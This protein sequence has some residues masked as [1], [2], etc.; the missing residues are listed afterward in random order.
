M[1][2]LPFGEWL[3]DGP[4]FANPGTI[5]ALNVVPRTASSYGPMPGPV[6]YT[7][8]LPAQVCGSYGYRDA[9]GVVFNFAA[10]KSRIYLQQTG[11]TAFTDI[12]GPSAPYNTENPPDG[13]WSMT[14]FGKRI[15]ATNYV[16]P[17]QTYLAGTDSAFSDLSPDAPRG[18]FAA[19]IRDFLMLGNTVDSRD[20]EVQFRLA[21]PAI[22][23][24]TNWPV[25]GSNEAIELQSDYQDLV[26]TDLGEVTQ[27]VGGHLSAADGAAFCER[28]IYRIGYSGSP[29]IFDFAVAEGAAGTDAS[30]SVVTRRLVDGGGVARSTCF[31]LGSDGFYAFDGSSSA[32][33]G[34][35]KVDRFFFGDLDPTYLRNVMGTYDPQRKLIFWFYHGQQNNGFFNRALVF[36]WELGRW[37]LLDLTPAPVEWVESS[38]YSTAGYNLD[39]MDPLGNLEQLKYSLDS[40]VWTAG[41]PMLGWFDSSHTQNY[42]TGPALPPT[43][44]T[45]ETQMFPGKRTRVISSRPLHDGQ[46]SAQVAV[47][48]RETTRQT[49]V[50]RAAVAE[51]I[52]GECP[53]RT[54]GRYTRYQVRLPPGAGFNFLQGVDVVARPEGV[55]S[56][57]FV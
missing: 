4:A 36:N 54:T 26:Q 30:L 23:D 51:N 46:V 18:R 38:S 45:S 2:L 9:A 17:V 29:K 3:P 43:I 13:F 16:D 28:G 53:Q 48:V 34:G 12:S 1:P 7:A 11:A 47:G 27:I 33:I 8:A 52:L 40:R 49:V 5:V 42:T 37:S 6:P 25:P 50:Y 56:Q 41:N 15:I 10:T 20:G 19:V 35:Q 32:S 14:S 31:Y 24:P 55:R 39:Q 44:E 22:G 57:G 21:W